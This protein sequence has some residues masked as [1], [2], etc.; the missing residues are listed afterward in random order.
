MSKECRKEGVRM[1]EKVGSESISTRGHLIPAFVLS[2]LNEIIDHI[3]AEKVEKCKQCNGSGEEISKSDLKYR[4][5]IVCSGTGLRE[6]STT[7]ILE[8]VKCKTCN[9]TGKSSSVIGEDEIAE[10]IRV[11]QGKESGMNPYL[12]EC[13]IVELAHAIA[14]RIK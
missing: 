6:N 12:A 5:C 10:V 9:G 7:T 2:K 4:T 11:R 13:D 8:D 14:E 3:N 1:I